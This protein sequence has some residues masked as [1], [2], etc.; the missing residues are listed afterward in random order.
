MDWNDVRTQFPV[1]QNWAFFDHAA[2]APLTKAAGEAIGGYVKDL[3]EN[4]DAN[5][6]QWVKR[7]GDVRGLVARLLNAEA[8]DVAF[9]PNTS[10][11]VGYVAEGFPWQSGDNIVIAAE[12]YPANVYPWMNLS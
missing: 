8:T 12:E 2:V 4:G 6:P 9:I 11:G 5:E 10:S 3:T 7:V 1:T